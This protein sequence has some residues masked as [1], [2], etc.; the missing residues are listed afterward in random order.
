[1]TGFCAEELTLAFH[2]NC[3]VDVY[4]QFT[5]SGEEEERHTVYSG[6]IVMLCDD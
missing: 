1:M 3:D 5:V 2:G 6:N 4:S